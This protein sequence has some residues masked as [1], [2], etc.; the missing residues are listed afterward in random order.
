MPDC[1]GNRPSNRK[2]HFSLR[3]LAALL[4]LL[5][6]LLLLLLPLRA[7]FVDSQDREV[8]G[9]QILACGSVIGNASG[10][11]FCFASSEEFQG[12]VL[13][14]FPEKYE[15]TPSIT[16][17]LLQKDA[18]LSFNFLWKICTHHQVTRHTPP[19][20]MKNTSHLYDILFGDIS[21]TAVTGT[22]PRYETHPEGMWSS[23]KNQ[24]W[25]DQHAQQ[26]SAIALPPP[27]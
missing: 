10:M 26:Q 8:E 7:C 27:H 9:A 4:L 20:C 15:D 22:M 17:F 5:P 25:E 21:G 24:L 13:V 23:A 14:I 16:S 6:L 12:R 2:P 18:S 11:A 19:I 1:K 3:C